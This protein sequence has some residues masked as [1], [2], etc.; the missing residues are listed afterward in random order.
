MSIS[1]VAVYCFENG[2]TAD[3]ENT[4]S[5]DHLAAA[6]LLGEE[7]A[8]RGITLITGGMSGGLMGVVTNA[9]LQ[10]GGRVIGI[11]PKDFPDENRHPRLSDVH[12]VDVSM[13]RLQLLRR[14]WVR[15]KEISK[16]AAC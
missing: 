11:I 6:I 7:F 2:V 3:L 8:K 12:I 1:S 4:G 10:A 16:T 15:Q 14:I 13:R 5:E 9:A